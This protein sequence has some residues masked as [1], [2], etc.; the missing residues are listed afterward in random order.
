M[1]LGLNFSLSSVGQLELSVAMLHSH[2]CYKRPGGI[3]RSY[4]DT[5]ACVCVRVCVHANVSVHR[6][7][8]LGK[9]LST[10]NLINQ[11]VPL[12]DMK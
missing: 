3:Y 8:N 7:T 1:S 4:G 11:S 5:S 12:L 10:G 6:L 9:A 2:I